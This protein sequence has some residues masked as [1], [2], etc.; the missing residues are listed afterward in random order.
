MRKMHSME[1]DN[2]D[3]TIALADSVYDALTLDEKFT[4]TMIH[5]E[6][7]SQNCDPI[8]E[9][10]HED[11]RIYG[12]MP[13][14]FTEYQ[15]SERQLDF[16]KTNRDSVMQLLRAVFLEQR[17]VGMNSLDAIVEMNAR[18]MIPWL[19]DFYRSDNSNHYI[20][21]ALMMLMEKNKYPEFMGS[22]SYNKLYGNLGDNY[23]AYLVYSKGNEDLI[24]QR[25]TNFI[26]TNP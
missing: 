3:E 18:Q 14:Y 16:L 21:T 2:S 6:N 10:V 1:N 17:K 11:K 20:L 4:Y 13:N 12:E 8:P 9:R 5:A 26:H 22:I 25:A 7:F 23:S 19:I 15:W 24:I